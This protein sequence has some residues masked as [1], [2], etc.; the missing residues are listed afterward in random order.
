MRKRTFS[1]I[2]LL[3][4]TSAVSFAAPAFGQGGG[5]T[6]H[7]EHLGYY[8]PNAYQSR[9]LLYPFYGGGYPWYDYHPYYGWHFPSNGAERPTKQQLN[10]P[11][12][13]HAHIIV[14]APAG[15]VL[16][17]NGT[18]MTGDGEVRKFVSPA[19]TPGQRY[20]YEVRAQWKQNGQMIAKTHELTV[21]AGA[22]ID[23]DFV[24]SDETEK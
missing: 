16:W 7:L 22:H 11:Q 5:P 6:G 8:N 3:A 9:Y 24:Q 15:A 4:L 10:T 20:S 12:D 19:L 23:V 14:R 13:A 21:K 2:A 17:F 18:K 1:S